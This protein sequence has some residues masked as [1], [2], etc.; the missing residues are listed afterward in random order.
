MVAEN[1]DISQRNVTKGCEYFVAKY[2]PGGIDNFIVDS[3][4]DSS[5]G[6]MQNTKTVPAT[7]VMNVTGDGAGTCLITNKPKDGLS[8]IW[9]SGTVQCSTYS[10]ES[11]C[12]IVDLYDRKSINVEAYYMMKDIITYRADDSKRNQTILDNLVTFSKLPVL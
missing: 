9:F 8:N 5:I 7:T 11:S 12:Y 4:A 1:R 6:Y 10:A 3:K 2:L